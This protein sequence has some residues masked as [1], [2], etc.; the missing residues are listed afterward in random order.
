M[1]IY[2]NWN[3]TKQLITFN[4]SIN[5]WQFCAYDD[6]KSELWVIFCFLL[7]YT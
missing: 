6:S 2:I 5:W 1:K 3:L 7:N 4:Y